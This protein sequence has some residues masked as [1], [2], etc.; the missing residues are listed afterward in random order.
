VHDDT[1]FLRVPEPN[2]D[3]LALRSPEDIFTRPVP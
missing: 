2:A 1:A 3:Q